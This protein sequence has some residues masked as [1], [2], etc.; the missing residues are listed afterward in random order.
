MTKQ[1]D[2]IDELKSKLEGIAHDYSQIDEQLD[3]NERNIR[4][5]LV[6]LSKASCREFCDAIYAKFPRELRDLVYEQLTNDEVFITKYYTEDDDEDVGWPSC[7]L[8]GSLALGNHADFP[9]FRDPEYVGHN[10]VQ[11]LLES[12]LRTAT[13]YFDGLSLV[14]EFLEKD[15]LALGFAPD[16]LL[17]S[18]AFSIYESSLDGSPSWP[19]QFGPQ[20]PSPCEKMLRDMEILF[21]FRKGTHI[22]ISFNANN[23]WVCAR[24][25]SSKIPKF[26]AILFPILN[27]L[28]DAGFEVKVKLDYIGWEFDFKNAEFSLQGWMKK[29]EGVRLRY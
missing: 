4:K 28:K 21:R 26:L 1:L 27:R 2:Q 11:E 13:F 9:Y 23:G 22:R 6:P 7:F 24:D 3:A 10:M 18:V 20:G 8:G 14:P 29:L 17:S 5:H 16:K 12:W 15:T 19:V 25:R